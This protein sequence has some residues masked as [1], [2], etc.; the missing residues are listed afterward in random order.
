MPRTHDPDDD[1][2]KDS[3]MSFGD[4]IEELR[5]RLLN[6][7][8]ALFFCVIISVGLDWVGKGMDNP[9]IGVGRPAKDE[10]RRGRLR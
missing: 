5:Y 2:F 8:K 9:Y 6:A 4:H 3:R 10:D 1:I 7:V